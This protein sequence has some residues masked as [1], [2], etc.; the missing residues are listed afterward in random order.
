LDPLREDVL[1]MECLRTLAGNWTTEINKTEETSTKS[2]KARDRLLRFL[3][4]DALVSG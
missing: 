2:R 3:Q 4:V 1:G